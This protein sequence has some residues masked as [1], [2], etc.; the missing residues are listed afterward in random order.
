MP[1]TGGLMTGKTGLA[2]LWSGFCNRLEPHSP[3][4]N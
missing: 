2:V 3:S 4:T 1:E